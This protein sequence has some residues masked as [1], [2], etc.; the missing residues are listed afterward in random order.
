MFQ[1]EYVYGNY[2]GKNPGLSAA[3]AGGVDLQG[4]FDSMATRPNMQ[5][6]TGFRVETEIFVLI[7]WW[8]LIGPGLLELA[9]LIFAVCTIVGNTRKRKVPL[10]KSSALVLLACRHDADA[11]QIQGE[12]KDVKDLK[13]VAK[14][15]KAQL[16]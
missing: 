1:S 8:W 3:L 7:R 9:A 14:V 4:A 11:G 16:E 6:A 15:S 12:F 10:W 2:D 13:K 5:L